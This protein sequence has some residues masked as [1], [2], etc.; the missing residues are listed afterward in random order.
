MIEKVSSLEVLYSIISSDWH[1]TR[2]RER[3]FDTLEFIHVT[4]NLRQ[5]LL[6]LKTSHT[7]SPEHETETHG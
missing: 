4:G 7:Q 3:A 2:F 5:G 6:N 1:M